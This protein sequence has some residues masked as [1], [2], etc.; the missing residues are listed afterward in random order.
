MTMRLEGKAS[1]VLLLLVRLEHRRDHWKATDIL[2]PWAGW[3][4]VSWRRR[5]GSP[6][7]YSTGSGAHDG[8]VR[9]RDTQGVSGAS[10]S[11]GGRGHRHWVARPVPQGSRRHPRGPCWAEL[12]R[13]LDRWKHVTG[14]PFRAG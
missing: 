10:T 14:A 5:S 9:P 13:S 11:G 2:E 7:R 12:D 4:S 1:G 3:S 6:V 8:S